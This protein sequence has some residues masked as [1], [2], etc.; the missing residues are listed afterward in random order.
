MFS[1]LFNFFLL[2]EVATGGVLQKKGVLKNL[3]KFTGKHMRQSLLF[4]KVAGACNFI[5]KESLAHVFPVNFA[6][7]LRTPYL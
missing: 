7:F 2:S 1:V 5:K 4:N 3:A 6:K